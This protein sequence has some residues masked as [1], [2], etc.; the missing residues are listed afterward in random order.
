ML[1]HK[2]TRKLVL[3]LQH[4][5]RVTTVIP[6]A[7]TFQFRGQTLVAVPHRLEETIV[8]R[9]LGHAAPSPVKCFYDFPGRFKPFQ[10][11]IETVDFL[12]TNPRAFVLNSIGT[13]KTLSA[14]WA[15]DYL[16]SIGKAN[17]MLVV[18]PLS[19]LERVWCDE[20]FANLPH[21]TVGVL[22]GS[23]E[24]R[25]KVLAGDYDLWVIN[26]HGCDVILNDLIAKKEIDTILIDEVSVFRNANTNLWKALNKICK[27]RTRV[28]GM[29]GT[30]V[31]RSPEDA[32]GQCK[33]IVPGKVP[34]Y[35]G[36]WRDLVMK[37]LGHFNWVPRDNATEL[38]SNA[39]RPAIRFTRE[40]CI[41]LPPV[42]Y[43][44]RQ[45][46]LTPEQTSAYKQML[47][48][49]KTEVANKQILAVNSAVQFSKLVQVACG[50]VYSR[51]GE[52]V[53][54][55]NDSR[56]NVV[57][58][59]IDEAESKVIVY[60]PFRGALHNVAEQLRQEYG[61][62]AVAEICGETPKSQRDTIFSAFQRASNP[63]IL[64][65]QPAS[66]SHG[67]TLIAASV[68]IWYAPVPNN[69]VYEQA[70]GRIVRPGQ[71]YNQLIVHIEGTPVERK[72]YKRLQQR[73]SM[74][75][76]L[77]DIVEEETNG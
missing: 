51:D 3:K 44:T 50:C 71:K 5:E 39:M 22:H 18:A 73:Q 41:D 45:V 65:A 46:A 64:V 21:L 9:N 7:R 32:Y 4:P 63:R 42:T 54:L 67:L 56:L 24:R 70:N 29:T 11:Q 60:L 68:V 16:R 26:H 43:T 36:Q 53:T 6:S 38:V 27:D 55:P 61:H 19:T 72:I 52:A 74:Q 34:A 62:D 48:T 25:R 77:L 10:S 69:E 15:F 30:P 58:E 13:G 75:N 49:L 57:K 40:Q 23:K 28:W 35:Y 31:P 1:V 37:K 2:P 14:L 17:K 12:T 47:A 8:L 66:M 33:L 20:T 76:L 59:I